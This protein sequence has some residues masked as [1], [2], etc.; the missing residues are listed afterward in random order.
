MRA[1][2]PGAKSRLNVLNL[3]HVYDTNQGAGSW[4]ILTRL[5]HGGWRERAARILGQRGLLPCEGNRR[6]RRSC[7]RDHRSAE[8]SGGRA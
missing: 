8:C 2:W 1:L 7:T 6:W 5:L 4:P 3:A